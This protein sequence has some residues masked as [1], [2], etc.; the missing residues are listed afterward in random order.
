M[1]S[2]NPADLN[3]DNQIFVTQ[4]CDFVFLLFQNTANI[5]HM[6]VNLYCLFKRTCKKIVA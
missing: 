3:I 2:V 4:F 5:T 1:F 6:S